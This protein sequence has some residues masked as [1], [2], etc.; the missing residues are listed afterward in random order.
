MLFDARTWNRHLRGYVIHDCAISHAGRLHFTLGLD[1]GKAGFSL[2]PDTRFLCCDLDAPASRR[3]S[4]V[5]AL[6][7]GPVRS[8]VATAPSLEL[9]AVDPAGRLYRCPGRGAPTQDAPPL[10]WK[11]RLKHHE[12]HVRNLKR[13]GR[14]VYALTDARE[15]LRRQG[16]QRWVPL[17]A[18][19]KGAP[20]PRATGKQAGWSTGFND[21]DGFASDDL[22]AVGGFGDVWHFDGKDWTKLPFAKDTLVHTVCCAG[23]GNVY[24]TGHRGTLWVGR[25]KQWKRLQEG[26]LP[27]SEFSDSAWFAG[28]LYCGT[29][30]GL[31]VKTQQGRLR[32]VR[33]VDPRMK[34][35]VARCSGRIGLSPDGTRMLS[36]SHRG[37]SLFDGER[38]TLLFKTSRPSTPPRRKMDSRR[39]P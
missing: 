4:H 2:A 25:G 19:A 34:A 13:V 3:F 8:A 17:A 9:V 33:E 36:A 26:G 24:I 22:Y 32:P 35:D 39:K 7:L 28:A 16:A 6:N 38:W 10:P 20:F 31:W 27:L 29:H 21:L 18:S 37:A 23:D 11:P 15:I 5:D 1:E 12:G 14:H 30:K